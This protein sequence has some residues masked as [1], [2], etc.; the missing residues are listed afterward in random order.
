MQIAMDETKGGYMSVARISGPQVLD[1]PL[2]PAQHLVNQEGIGV[3]DHLRR[4]PGREAHQCFRQGLPEPEL[5]LGTGEDDLH[6]LPLPVLLGSL[7]HQPDAALRQGRLQRATP[8]GEVPEEPA[9]RPV[10][11]P[12][13]GQ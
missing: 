11:E 5:A 4:D 3:G 7:G 9:R 1:A 8:V 10:A 2:R 12:S 13:L 6:L